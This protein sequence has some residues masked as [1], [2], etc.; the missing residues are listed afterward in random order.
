MSEHKWYAIQTYAGSEMAVKRAI[1]NLV[2][3]NKIEERLKEIVV[4]TEDVIEFKN[5][6]EKI[7]ERSLYSGYVF[8]NLNL[9]TELWHRIQSLPK[10]GRFI[11]ESKNP[12]P[13]SEKDINLILEKAYNKAAPKPKISFEEGENVRITEGPFAN[14]TGIVEEYDM[15]RGLLKL[16]VSIFG[17]ST[18]VEILYSQVEKVI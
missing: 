11:G 6:K 9:D 16:N 12:T 10:V 2:K 14:F 1:E 5:G 15:V 4:P 13:L 3:D 8:A 17:R 7:S 18:P